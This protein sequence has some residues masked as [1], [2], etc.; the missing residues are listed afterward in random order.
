MQ[1]TFAPL[2]A[3]LRRERTTMQRVIIFCQRLNDCSAMYEFFLS[4]LKHEFTEPI[5]APNVSKFRLVDMY[6]SLTQKEVQDNI[7][8]SFS[9]ATSSLRIVICTIA[10]GMGIDC[11]G[12]NQ[13]IH[14]RPPAD[15][16]SYMQESGRAGRNGQPS[17]AVLY[18]TKKDSRHKATSK[19]M[20]NYYLLQGSCRRTL[21]CS[22][23]NCNRTEV[24]GCACCDFCSKS[25]MCSDCRCSTYP[26]PLL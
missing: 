20:K 23:F 25:C 11:A 1:E 6:T 21:L 8:K 26:I 18:A 22:Y 2:A 19:E 17:C 16:E 24:H 13:V 14:W 12:V 9:S 5:S 7:V 4:I 15:L 10:F 3:K